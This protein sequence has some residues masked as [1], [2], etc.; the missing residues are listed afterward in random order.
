M[1]IIFIVI[2]RLLIHLNIPRAFIITTRVLETTA[3]GCESGKNKNPARVFYIYNIVCY[4]LIYY[5]DVYN[6]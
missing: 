5:N 1:Y 6:T 4:I 3:P 2:I